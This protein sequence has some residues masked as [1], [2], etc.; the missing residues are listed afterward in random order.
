MTGIPGM[1]EKEWTATCLADRSHWYEQAKGQ[2]RKNLQENRNYKLA[3]NLILF[4]G[5]GMGMTT[6]TTSRIYKGQLQGHSGE[7]AELVFDKF[8]H[9][10]LS[11][12]YNI[13]SQVGD[14]AACA[15]ALM[16]GVKGR[17]ETLGLDD[18]GEYDRCDS[19]FTSRVPCLIDWAQQAGKATGFVTTTRVTHATPAALYAHAASRYWES[20]DKLPSH[21]KSAC[22]DIARQLVEEDPGKNINIRLEKGVR[23]GDSI[24]PKL[25]TACLENVFR[26]L[27]WTSKGIPINGD[28]LTNLRF[29]DDVFLFSESPQELQLMVEELRTAS[30]KV[31]L[32]INLSKT[33]VM[34]NRNIEIQP[35]MTGNVALDQVDRYIYL[36]QLISIHR[37]WEPEV[38][39]RVALGWKA[40]GRLNNVWSSKLPL[41]LKRKVIMGGGRR[42]FLPNTQRD[43]EH[44][45]QFGRRT[46]GKNLI[47]DWRADKKARGLA[48][49]YVWRKKDFDRVDADQT[50]YL[51]GLFE[52]GHMAYNDLRD[53]GPSG[54]PSLAEMTEKAVDI[55][56]KKPYGYF[57]MVEGG[58]IDHSHHFSNAKRAIQETLELEKAIDI[59]M[60]K[61]NPENTLVVLTADHSHVFTFGGYP[62]RGNPIFGADSKLS[63]IDHMQ[64]T[65]LLYGNG[66]GYD[67]SF[68][69]G[70]Q[71]LSSINTNDINYIQQSAVPRRWETHGGEDVPVFAHGAMSHLFRGVIEQT[72]IPHALAYAACIGK[73]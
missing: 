42:H 21:A 48:A 50:D 63:D 57:L 30:S 35:I 65:T 1:P 44:P 34:F 7:E 37:D 19:T 40:F 61:I 54:E 52:Y 10:A 72:Y 18:K 4:V 69:R 51:L 43:P 28:K 15:T 26:G 55:L 5:D 70:R 3:E 71:N 2:I 20:N 22:K 38:R 24:S 33:K 49:Q 59:V 73:N 12:T 29:A 14:S 64:Y 41:C 11:K 68:K 17:F 46:D 31:G 36:G 13:D 16:C 32:E 47:D 67:R 9:S 25:F 45:S 8:S 23:Q 66:P 53:S 60:K 39:R 62:K 6:V 58:R 56:Q 27:N